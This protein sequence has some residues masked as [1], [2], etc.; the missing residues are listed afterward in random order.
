MEAQGIVDTIDACNIVVINCYEIFLIV[1]LLNPFAFWVFFLLSSGVF[2]ENNIDG[3][4]RA[5]GPTYEMEINRLNQSE[6][7]PCLLDIGNISRGR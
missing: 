6:G 4:E 7:A 1:F 3:C 2:K 5:A